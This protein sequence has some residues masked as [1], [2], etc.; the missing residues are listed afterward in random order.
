MLT[1]I[2]KKFLSIFSRKIIKVDDIIFFDFNCET[3][4]YQ[5]CHD[6]ENNLYYLSNNFGDNSLIFKKLQIINKEKFT[7]SCY[8]YKSK[9]IF[10]YAKTLEDLN[11][12]VIKLHELCQLK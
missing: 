10:P 7:F 3:F 11:K 6:S 1:K 2:R 12:M 8:G 9:G 4:T 5:V